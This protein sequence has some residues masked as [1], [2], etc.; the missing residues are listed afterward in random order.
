MMIDFEDFTDAVKK[1]LE[2]VIGGDEYEKVEKLL[3]AEGDEFNFNDAGID[4]LDML[5]VMYWVSQR[6]DKRMPE[7]H[8]QTIRSLYDEMCALNNNKTAQE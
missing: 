7:F 8:D 4:S 2:Y 1:A 3:S 5:D 6:L